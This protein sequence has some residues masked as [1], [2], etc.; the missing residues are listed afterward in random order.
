MKGINERDIERAA[1]IA[2][3]VNRAY[4]AGIGEATQMPWDAAPEWQKESARDGVRA[5]VN[6]PDLTPEQSHR[7]WLQHKAMNGWVYGTEKDESAKKHPCM[8]PYSNLPREQ[9]AK[10]KLFIIVVRSVLSL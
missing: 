8:V 1:M 10:D 4:C 7:K 9:R 3:E 5:L 2:H 6:D